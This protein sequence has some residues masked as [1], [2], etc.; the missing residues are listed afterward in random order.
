MILVLPIQVVLQCCC[1]NMHLAIVWYGNAL[2]TNND[3]ICCEFLSLY[4]V[5]RVLVFPFLV[6]DKVFLAT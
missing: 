4:K 6:S 3:N 5:R 2:F 1:M